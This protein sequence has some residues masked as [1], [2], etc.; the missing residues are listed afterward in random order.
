MWFQASFE[1]ISQSKIKTLQK[2]NFTKDQFKEIAKKSK[3]IT[4]N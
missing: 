4:P 2:N 1:A 3:T